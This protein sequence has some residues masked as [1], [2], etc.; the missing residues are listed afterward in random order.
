MSLD[1]EK[2]TERL[3]KLQD[4]LFL[5]MDELHVAF[6]T[7]SSKVGNGLTSSTRHHAVEIEQLKLHYSKLT[8]ELAIRNKDFEVR[9][10]RLSADLALLENNLVKDIGQLKR[11][12]AQEIRAEGATFIDSLRKHR[13]EEQIERSKIEIARQVEISRLAS[14]R[15]LY[16]ILGTLFIAIMAPLIIKFIDSIVISL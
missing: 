9:H 2:R 11:D 10:V 14:E 7:L 6:V 12:I 1:L 3:E 15:K 13:D 4:R 8:D 16:I 5:K